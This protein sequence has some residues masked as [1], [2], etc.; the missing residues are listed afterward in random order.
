ML[1]TLFCL[2]LSIPP[3]PGTVATC[4]PLLVRHANHAQVVDGNAVLSGPSSQGNSSISRRVGSANA[5]ERWSQRVIRDG[6][7]GVTNA[8]D[9]SRSDANAQ[10]HTIHLHFNQQ[11]RT[12]PLVLQ[13]FESCVFSVTL[14]QLSY[15]F[16]LLSWIFLFFS[17]C[18]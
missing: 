9:R 18:N 11:P 12:A 5:T 15:G 7:F 10:N 16:A 8:N 17:N 2:G 14:H 3:P 4:H 6:G 1:N 13:R